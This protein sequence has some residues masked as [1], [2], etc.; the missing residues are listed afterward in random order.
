[1]ECTRI[2]ASSGNHDLDVR[3]EAGEKIARW[4]NV[5]RQL[6]IPTD[7]DSVTLGGTLVTICPWWDGP[8]ARKAVAPQIERDAAKPR[9]SWVWVYH[10]P[11]SGSPTCWDGKKFYGDAELVAWIEAYKPDIVFAGYIQQAP[12]TQA[13]SWA[14]RIGSTWV[15]NCGNQI[16]PTPTHIIVDTDAREAAWFSLEGAETAQ[17]DLRCVVR[18]GH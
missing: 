6:G 14:D 12:F 18:C 16:G 17:L 13:G 8:H 4:M 1:M 10:A 3:D 2:I 7:G 5:V 15:F 11:P 9:T